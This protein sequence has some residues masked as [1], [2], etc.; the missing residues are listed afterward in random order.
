[1][2]CENKRDVLGVFRQADLVNL[3]WPLELETV[4]LCVTSEIYSPRTFV[5][6]WISMWSDDTENQSEPFPAIMPCFFTQHIY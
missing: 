2:G 3:K 4:R 6:Q 1:M 5:S